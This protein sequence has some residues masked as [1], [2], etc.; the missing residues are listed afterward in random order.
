M[1]TSFDWSEVAPAW[2]RHR[3]HVAAHGF[4]VLQAMV[5][6][7]GL[8]PG[9]RVLEVA[10]GTGEFGLRLAHTV[11]ES[12]RVLVTDAAPGM[13]ALARATLDGVGNAAV[14]QAEASSIDAPDASFDA[15]VCAMGLMFSPDPLRALKEWVRV[16]TPGGRVAA[17]TWAGPQ[18]NPWLSAL[19]M[20]AMA[21][22]IVAGGPPVGPGGIFSLA[23]PDTLAGFAKDAGLNEV[24]VEEVNITVDYASTDEHFDLVSS[25]AG[26]LSV[27][28]RNSSEEQRGAL[29]IGV[30][31]M[32]APY[33]NDHGLTVP[34]KALV[35]SAHK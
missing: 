32:L 29:R 5:N 33:V 9:D 18:H 11:G 2:D 26:P 4:N 7:A 22:G 28:V 19:G 13:V 34:G 14:A 17:A 15:V 25:L 3:D 16:L 23:E 12:G 21:H 20:T 30:A 35:L 1:E 6:A 8:K 31:A 10:A 24:L 27:A